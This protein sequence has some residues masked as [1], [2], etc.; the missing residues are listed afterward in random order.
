MGGG[1]GGGRK[2]KGFA[3]QAE[4]EDV[5][6]ESKRGPRMDISFFLLSLS[7]LNPFKSTNQRKKSIFFV[8]ITFQTIPSLISWEALEHC[9]V[10]VL[11]RGWGWGGGG[12]A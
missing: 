3:W 7:L 9:L 8:V 1:G 10:L 12:G 11:R 5:Q 4:R 2:K 6:I